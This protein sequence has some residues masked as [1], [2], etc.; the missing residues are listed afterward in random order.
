MW[1][2]ATVTLSADCDS[3]QFYYDIGRNSVSDVNSYILIDNVKVT[4]AS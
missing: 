1:T 3:L 4:A 2:T